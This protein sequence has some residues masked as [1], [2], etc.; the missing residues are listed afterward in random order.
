[1]GRVLVIALDGFESTVAEAFMASGHMPALSE[2][3]QRSARF[4]L[5]DGTAKL[6]GLSG[7][8][9]ASGMSP[10][11]SGR[12]SA[13]YFDKRSYEVWQA[14]VLLPPFLAKLKARTVVFDLPYCDL[15]R[16]PKVRGV[17]AWGAHDP[18]TDPMS[19]HGGQRRA[20]A[21]TDRSNTAP[22]RNGSHPICAGR[23]W[24]GR[25]RRKT[26]KPSPE[27]QTDG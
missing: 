4:A 23:A 3:R 15:T 16:A 17:S 10:E 27:H 14:G 25:A 8:H 7:E 13:V 20:L 22:I 26:Q 2:L 12:P 5:D 24:N 1:M 18:G 11:A 6:T 19:P 21:P 9:V